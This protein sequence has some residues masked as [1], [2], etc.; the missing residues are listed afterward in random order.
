MEPPPPMKTAGFPHSARQRLARLGEGRVV[1]READGAARAV[2]HELGPA[3][4]RQPRL[5]VLAEGGADLVRVLVEDEAERD[6]RRGHGG[7]DGLEAL[8]LVAAAHA[9]DLAGRPRPDHLERAAA[10]SPA[11]TESPI[12]PRKASALKPS[13][14]HCAASEFGSSGTPS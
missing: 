2:L 7:D 6:L 4:G 8:P 10:L 9:V 3:I 14:S 1:H 5:H 13:V 11:G 12:A